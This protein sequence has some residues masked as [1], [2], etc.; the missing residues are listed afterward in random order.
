MTFGMSN[1]FVR[2]LFA[3]GLNTLFGLAIYSLLALSNWATW[4]VLIVAQVAA[5]IFSFITTGGI[6]FQDM[7]VNVIPRFIISY[8]LIFIIYLILI[9]S[10]SPVCG[11]RIW[12]M[13]IVVAP[14]AGFT[15]FIQ[16]HFVFGVTNLKSPIGDS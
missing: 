10:L 14:M 8:S 1:R 3:G 7:R 2:F 12:A 16:S 15:Y 4:L 9:Q 5:T 11:G 6:V 13:V